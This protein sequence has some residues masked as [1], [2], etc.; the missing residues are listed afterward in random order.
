[1]GIC[2]NLPCSA[3]L[4]GVRLLQCAPG[5]H[6]VYGASDQW[7]G[8][9]CYGLL[10]PLGADQEV[11]HGRNHQLP[12]QGSLQ[13]PSSLDEVIMF[14]RAYEQWASAPICLAPPSSEASGCSSV[15]QGPAGSMV[16]ATSVRVSS[17]MVCSGRLVPTKKFSM[18]EI[19]DCLVKGLYFHYDEKFIPGHKEECRG[20]VSDDKVDGD[21]TD[22]TISLHALTGIQQHTS[23]TMQLWVQIGDATV[24][25]LLDSGSTQFSRHGSC[26]AHRP[27]TASGHQLLRHSGQWRSARLLR[28]LHQPRHQCRW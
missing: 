27:H 4:R 19:V 14:A 12:R 24:M 28:A 2:P 16:L 22:P 20:L 9:F 21:P 6:R 13:C 11:L 23:K 3:I 25:A 1:V 7:R 15:R 10:R 8:V 5:A 17:A 18:A 26:E